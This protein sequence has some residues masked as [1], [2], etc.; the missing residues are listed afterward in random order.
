MII[1]YRNYAMYPT[2]NVSDPEN[3]HPRQS[4]RGRETEKVAHSQICSEAETEGRNEHEY[5]F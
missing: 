1:Y 4:R 5:L 3:S 2:K